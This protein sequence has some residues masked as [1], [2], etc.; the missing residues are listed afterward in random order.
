MSVAGTLRGI[1]SD[2]AARCRSHPRLVAAAACAAVMASFV[3]LDLFGSLDRRLS[4]AWF[5]LSATKPSGRVVLVDLSRAASKRGDG[6]RLPRAQL[7]ELLDDIA[8]AGA[9]RV[10]VDLTLSGE[11]DG[12]GDAALEAALARL[13]PTRVALTSSAMATTDADGTTR[14]RRS[15]VLDRFARHASLVG[16]D[17][18]FDADGSLRRFGVDAP[19]LP[20]IR[21]E[22]DWL[23][24]HVADADASRRLD[25]S[26]DVREVPVVD[27]S[28]VGDAAADHIAFAG[29]NVVVT[30]FASAL[31]QGVRVPRFGI[32]QRPEIT[33]LSIET[34][35][36]DRPLRRVGA[37]A[38][39][40]TVVVLSVAATL[41]L[42]RLGAVLGL[43]AA[44]ASALALFSAAASVQGE[45][46]LIIPVAGPVLAMLASY[47]AAQI[48]VHP[49]LDDVRAALAGMTTR[50]DL[51]LARVLDATGE[52]LVTFAPDGR[53]LSMNAAARHLFADAT[54][55]DG[56]SMA[57]LIGE[58]AGDLLAATAASRPGHVE[59]TIARGGKCQ[60]HLDLRV[61][62]MPSE[63][64]AW[65]GIAT[66]RDVTEHRAQV[67][68]LRR[69]AAE[70]PLTGLANRTG[71]ER[72]V[73]DGC[74]PSM[75]DGERMAVLM[76]DLDGFKAVNDTLGHQAGDALLREI[77]TRLLAGVPADTVVARLGGD[78]FGIVM[79]G[80]ATSAATAS[81]I[82]E[83]LV[84]AVAKP[85]TID[86]H[87]VE[88]G[89][90]IGV[91]LRSTSGC[92][93][94][95]LIGAADADMYRAKR[96]RA[97]L[98]RERSR[99]A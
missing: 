56:A 41:W 87:P 11:S 53:I 46:G 84:A 12:A 54:M 57:D 22:A 2:L 15:A 19:D 55:T 75:I 42:T 93:P 32:L 78:E 20:P 81:A 97:G 6:L 76:C 43:S 34:V 30:N 73:A 16:S 58:R 59:A 61:N 36:R 27:A 65:I 63:A 13:G 86:G 71:F 45:R 3:I 25:F 39:W 80:P 24:A 10:L 29:R 49:A 90:S 68:A 4:D 9:E 31:G 82:A 99:A 69:M 51:R 85:I 74:A 44:I 52:A 66:V 47:V 40:L 89:V 28:G 88:V 70:D 8:S 95:E 35:L 98:R 64:G 67:D 18:A 37:L 21:S 62:A 33:L 23:A 79:R 14:W 92:S 38:T 72:A 48:A 26:I 96:A 1:A 77:G 83:D 5:G 50:L 91:A 7:A 17:L 94:A 60:Q